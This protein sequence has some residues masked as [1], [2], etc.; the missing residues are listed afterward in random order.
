MQPSDWCCRLIAQTGG[1]GRDDPDSGPGLRLGG[2]AENEGECRVRAALACAR[3][4]RGLW[5]GSS[6]SKAVGTG[7]LVVGYESPYLL[8]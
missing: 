2:G 4:A 5:T 7:C 6:L 1:A 3:E 8:I